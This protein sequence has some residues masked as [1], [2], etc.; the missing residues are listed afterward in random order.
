VIGAGKDE[1]VTQIEH[2]D[3]CVAF[4]EGT[5]NGGVGL[6]RENN[7]GARLTDDPCR[8]MIGKSGFRA[9]DD[10]LPFIREQND[11]IVPLSFFS[12]FVEPYGEASFPAE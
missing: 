8:A 4:I 5:K 3:V 9:C 11:E 1:F 10:L 6:G 12:G 2:E 7:G